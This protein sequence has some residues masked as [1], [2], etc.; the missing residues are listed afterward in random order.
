MDPKKIAA[1][2]LGPVA[3][4]ALGFIT[5]PIITWFFSQEDI[6]RLAMLNVVTSFSILLFSLGLDQA[7]VREFHE[8]KSK[9]ALFKTVIS[10]GLLLLVT[11][12]IVLISSNN[13]ISRWLFEVDSLILSLFV[14]IA[15]LSTFLSRFLSLILRMN[16]QGLAYSMSQFLP[17]L[18]LISIVVSYVTFSVTKNITNLLLANLSASLFVCIIFS[19]NTRKDWLSGIK[20]KID[21][22]YL[23]SLLK[24]GAPLILGGLA[25]WGLTATDKILLKELSDF[26]QLGLYSVAV[27]FAAAATIFQN[28][29]STIWAPTVYKWAA[30]GENFDK[31][32]S[33]NRY[34]LLVVIILFCMAGLF[35]WVVTLIL[36]DN[37]NSVQWVLIPCLGFPL[38][39]TLSE[40][41][42]IGIGVTRRSGFAMLAAI[43]AFLVNFLG[44]WW[45]IPIWGAAGAAVSTCVS[46]WLFFVLRTEFSIY[47]WKP[48]PRIAI[49]TYS[50]L[51]VIGA[52]FSCLYGHTY[53]EYL[54]FFWVSVLLSVFI[55]FKREIVDA[56]CWIEKRVHRD[57]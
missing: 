47:V 31:V 24:F 35:S 45:L 22:T 15:I 16:E 21:Y 9:P 32:H 43:L 39:Y 38:L 55:F 41:T 36:P 6:G 1:F 3:G 50:S 18:L 53:H 49:Y 23:N 25:F 13:V 46:F 42:V 27:S 56:K 29:F 20:E 7:Y 40:T 17:K 11:T 28:I 51:L 8:A 44:N 54:V 19:W 10:P 57:K 12:L 34:V 5:L 2:A 37:Y 52:I 26:E 48:I 14:A 4:A 30:A 33:V